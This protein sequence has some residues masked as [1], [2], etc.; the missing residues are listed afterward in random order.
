MI[1]L[2][3]R[4]QLILSDFASDRSHQSRRTNDER[5]YL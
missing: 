1:A 4:V 5:Y 3:E 2:T